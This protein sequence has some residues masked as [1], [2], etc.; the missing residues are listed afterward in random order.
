MT[1]N[2]LLSVIQG[3]V[4]ITISRHIINGETTTVSNLITMYSGGEEQ[5]NST[6]LAE[7]VTGVALLGKTRMQVWLTDEVVPQPTPPTP[8]VDP[9]EG[10]QT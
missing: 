10:E 6:F 3:E 8:D 1:V 5:L 4:K 2:D 9:E 7:T